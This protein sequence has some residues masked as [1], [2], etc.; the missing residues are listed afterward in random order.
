[1]AWDV[2]NSGGT[3]RPVGQ[4]TPNGWG[5]YDIGGNVFEWTYDVACLYPAGQTVAD[6]YCNTAWPYRTLR[7]GSWATEASQARAA[8]RLF[9]LPEDRYSNVGFRLVRTLP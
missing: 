6:Y 2:A 9:A 1:M 3:I 7:G 8:Q 4:K 5:L